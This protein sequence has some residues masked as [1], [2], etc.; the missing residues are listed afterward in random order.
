MNVCMAAGRFHGSTLPWEFTQEP[1]QLVV[2]PTRFPSC[3]LALARVLEVISR[4]LE[5][6]H[7]MPHEVTNL[8]QT[9]ALAGNNSTPASLQRLS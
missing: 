8:E 7:S 1:G 9:A 2:V 5:V 4:S 3:L 6:P